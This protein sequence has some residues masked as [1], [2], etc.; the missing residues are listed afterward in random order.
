MLLCSNDEIVWVETAPPLFISPKVGLMGC[1]IGLSFTFIISSRYSACNGAEPAM[2]E[3]DILRVML[4]AV[5]SSKLI[6]D[7]DLR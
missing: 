7:P 5:L 1:K 2:V 6:M 3:S 4:R